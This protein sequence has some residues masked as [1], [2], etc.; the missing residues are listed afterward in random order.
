[1]FFTHVLFY[2]GLWHLARTAF[3]SD[4]CLLSHIYPVTGPFFSGA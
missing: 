3:V 4:T 2:N 1:M